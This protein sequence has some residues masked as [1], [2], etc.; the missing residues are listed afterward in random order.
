MSLYVPVPE[1]RCTW[2]AEYKDGT[3]TREA[4][5]NSYKDINRDQLAK[6]RLI[7]GSSVVFETWPP[8][9]A[10]GHNLVYRRRSRLGAGGDGPERDVIFVVGWVPMGPAFA[11]NLSA[12]TYRKLDQGFTLGDPELAPP[13][14]MPGEAFFDSYHQQQ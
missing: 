13:A 6:F 1:D 3:V 10:T 2:E 11:I 9:S 7:H 4:E 14:P 12:G 5:G 8:G